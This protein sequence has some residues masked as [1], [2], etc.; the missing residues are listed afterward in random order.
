MDEVSS[1]SDTINHLLEGVSRKN[2][3]IFICGSATLGKGMFS[4][5]LTNAW[6]CD[7]GNE[8]GEVA[9]LDLDPSRPEM[10]LPGHI[11]VSLV[12]NPLNLPSFARQNPDVRQDRILAHSVGINSPRTDINNY[13]RCVRALLEKAPERRRQVICGPDIPLQ[14]GGRLFGA[15][16]SIIEATDV[17]FMSEKTK[18]AFKAAI[19]RPTLRCHLNSHSAMHQVLRPQIE[20]HRRCLQAYFHSSRK[21]RPAPLKSQIPYE[22]SYQ[23]GKG[24]F[25]AV[26]VPG[27]VTCMPP[28]WLS[29]LLNGSIVTIIILDEDYPLSD[30]AIRQS[31]PDE[32]PYFA[33]DDDGEVERLDPRHSRSA[34]LG[35]VRGIDGAGRRLHVIT[36]ELLGRM[37]GGRVV[38]ELDGYDA[39]WAYNEDAQQARM[40]AEGV[41]HDAPYVERRE[42]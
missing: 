10:S 32:I 2:G 28:N 17:V 34:G 22:L 21:L 30:R 36:P 39:T 3:V 33:A 42:S 4:R 40:G 29:T 16:L 14:S 38:L 12:T 31:E 7:D 18:D 26:L 20:D 15:L 5:L 11:S 23:E 8:D 37:P 19:A 13:L 41:S 35:L 24:G 6:I 25:L 27:E 1:W 9:F